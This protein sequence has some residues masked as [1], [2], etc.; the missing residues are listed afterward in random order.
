MSELSKIFFPKKFFGISVKY[1]IAVQILIIFGFAIF[2]M[3]DVIKNT[4][5]SKVLEEKFYKA[6]LKGKII[7]IEKDHG[8]C[9][10][11][12]DN[13]TSEYVV[14]FARNNNYSPNDLSDFIKED[15]YIT[16]EKNSNNLV[17][18]N[19]YRFTLFSVIEKGN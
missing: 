1:F 9:S 2:W 15:S 8:T 10:F 12:L 4:N 18:D 11:V 14:G 3:K 5:K 16:K 7:K 6:E 17:V 13:D 19:R